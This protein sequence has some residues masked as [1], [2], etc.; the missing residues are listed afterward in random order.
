MENEKDFKK[1]RKIKRNYE[2]IE[3]NNFIGKIIK[4]KRKELN[5]APTDIASALNITYST[6]YS[7]ENGVINIPPQNLFKITKILNISLDE[8]REFYFGVKKYK[9]NFDY[10]N[11]K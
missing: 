5:I 3:F 2:I 11:K 8:C 7:Y 1:F 4:G 6:Y 10:F 9:D